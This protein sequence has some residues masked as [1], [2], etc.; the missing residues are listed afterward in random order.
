MNFTLATQPSRVFIQWSNTISPCT[1]PRTVLFLIVIYLLLS[2]SLQSN[3]KWFAPAV[4]QY[5]TCS[6]YPLAPINLLNHLMNFT[7]LGG[8]H[9]PQTSLY[10]FVN[11]LYIECSML[12][13][14]IRQEEPESQIQVILMTI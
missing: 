7:L 13:M 1:I 11:F 9:I 8:F 5:G 12:I 10:R 3:E 14:V 2:K 4:V 6:L